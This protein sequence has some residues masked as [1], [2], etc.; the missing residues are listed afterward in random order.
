MI[1]RKVLLVSIEIV[2]FF[3]RRHFHGIVSSQLLV[4]PGGTC[5]LR[6]NAYEVN[7]IRHFP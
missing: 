1:G 2:K 3:Y 7:A 5:F 6:T 4:Q